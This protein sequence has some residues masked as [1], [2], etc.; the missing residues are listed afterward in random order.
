MDVAP[1]EGDGGLGDLDIR[2]APSSGPGYPNS[3]LL[4]HKCLC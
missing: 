1:A 2:L 3:R 4:L